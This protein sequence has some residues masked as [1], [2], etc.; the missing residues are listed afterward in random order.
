MQCYEGDQITVVWIVKD[1]DGGHVDPQIF[2][3]LLSHRYG[4][5]ARGGCACAGPYGHRLLGI[6]SQTSARLRK[7]ILAGNEA[8]KPG[9]VRLNFS[10][11]MDDK[12]AQ[13]IIDSVNALSHD[14][15]IGNV[16]S[17]D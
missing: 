1:K 4:I 3:R 10:Y 12:T 6:D 13:F 2:T 9:W 11:L 14:L 16:S 15:N 17:A 7:E 5:Q 8:A